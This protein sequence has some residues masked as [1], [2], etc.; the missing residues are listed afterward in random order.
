MPVTALVYDAKLNVG[1]TVAGWLLSFTN[2]FP[3]WPNTIG[4]GAHATKLEPATTSC[5]APPLDFYCFQGA[6]Q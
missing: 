6:V 3:T 5:M 1:G 2:G 4:Q